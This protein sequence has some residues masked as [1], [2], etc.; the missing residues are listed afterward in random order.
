VPL[1]RRLNNVFS[2]FKWLLMLRQRFSSFKQHFSTFKRRFSFVGNMFRRWNNVFDGFIS[3]SNNFFDVNKTFKR[4]NPTLKWRVHSSSS[5]T[6]VKW[7]KFY[8][9]ARCCYF[10][11]ISHS[12]SKKKKKWFSN[13]K[14]LLF[15]RTEPPVK[16]NSFQTQK[17]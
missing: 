4:H 5:Y 11:I 1:C 10:T 2:T 6:S 8:L 12:N 14:V 17:K 3:R 9:T 16:E 13:A 15:P 7:Y